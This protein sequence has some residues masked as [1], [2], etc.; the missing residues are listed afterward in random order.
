MDG[1]R[2]REAP[3]DGFSMREESCAKAA[4]SIALLIGGNLPVDGCRWPIGRVMGRECENVAK[5]HLLS[6]P[7]FKEGGAERRKVKCAERRIISCESKESSQVDTSFLRCVTLL[8][9]S[10]A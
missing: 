1:C 7:F 8:L 5:R 10:L 3:D 2:W 4:I 9:R 6:L